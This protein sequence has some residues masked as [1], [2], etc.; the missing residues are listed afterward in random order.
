[1]T[2]QSNDPY[3]NSVI[4][5]IPEDVRGTFS[6][7]QLAELQQALSKVHNRSRHLVDVRVQI[8]LYWT[9]Y[10]MVFLLGRDMRSHVQE[11]LINR[12]QR[13]SRAAQ[14][15]FISL[16]VWLL[17]AGIVVTAFIV[18]YLIKSAVGINI[19]PDKHLSDF[20]GF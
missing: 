5:S 7:R 19:F 3:T 8:P 11:I 10:Y 14:I 6:S 16:A 12:R 15:G 4:N 9:R 2:T 13:D 1:M 17:L 18:L 20:L